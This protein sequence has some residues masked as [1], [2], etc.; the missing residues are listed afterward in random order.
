[1]QSERDTWREAALAAQKRLQAQDG[2]AERDR[3]EL[4]IQRQRAASAEA[5]LETL[6]SEAAEQRAELLEVD[7]SLLRKAVYL[8]NL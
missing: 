6:R 4:T 2:D 3:V 1:M 5:A 7:A 8:N